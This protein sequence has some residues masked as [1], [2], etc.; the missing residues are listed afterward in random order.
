[1]INPLENQKSQGCYSMRVKITKDI[2]SLENLNHKIQSCSLCP[3]L[4]FWRE[5]ISKDKP[6][7]FRDYTYWGKPVPGF[8]DIRAR[9]IIVGLAPGAHGSN[10]TGRM[11]TGDASGKFLYSAL[12]RA[13]LANRVESIHVNDGLEL[14]DCYITAVVRCV[15][16]HNRPTS[17]EILTCVENWLREE[18]NLLKNR[19]IL[20][21]LG[22]IAH[23]GLR[24]LFDLPAHQFPFAHG[25]VHTLPDGTFLIDSYHVSRQNT[26]TGRLNEAMFDEILNKAKGL[27]SQRES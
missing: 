8:G 25:N 27:L 21:A 18:L 7:R 13:G 4:V 9:L 24:S 26:Q 20:L 11:F 16:P 15:P 12:F 10:R 14:R 1:M 19:K 22:R 6:K 2:V 23:E 17:K 3:R 5:K